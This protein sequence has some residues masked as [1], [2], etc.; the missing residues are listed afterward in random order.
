VAYACISVCCAYVIVSFFS[1]ACKHRFFFQ[2]T[3]SRRTRVIRL[4]DDCGNL[5]DCTL[6]FGYRPYYHIKI[7]GGLKR[8]AVA[9]RFRQ[10][11]RVMI[12][13]PAAGSNATL[14]FRVMRR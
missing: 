6:K 14:F 12:S 9:R 13:A 4:I 1:D 2:N 3:L 10:G 7:G 8:M 5:W 11:L